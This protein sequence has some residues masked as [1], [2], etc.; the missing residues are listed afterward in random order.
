MK[1]RAVFALAALVLGLAAASALAAKD[2]LIVADQY[3]ATTMDPIGHNDVPS[4]RCCFELYDTLIFR[5]KDGNLVPGLAESW[6]FLSPTE[7]KFVLRKGVKFHNGEELKASDV[8]YTIMRATTDKGAKIRTYSQ[9][10]ADVK[11]LDDYTVVVVL[12]KPDYSF[13]GS[14]THSWGSILNEK[15]T[16]AAGDSYGTPG[17]PAVGTGP[18]T[19]VKWEKSNKYILERNDDFWGKKPAYKYLEVRAIPEPTNRTIELETKGVDIAYPII[20]NDINRI[21]DNEQLTRKERID[22]AQIMQ[23]QLEEVGIKAEIKVLEWGAYL[24]GLQEQKHDMFE[25]GW[26]SSV[27]DPNFAIS[28][29]LETKAGSNYTFSSDPKLD[30]LLAKKLLA[31]AGFP[32]GFKCEIW[33]NERKERIDMAQIMQ[34]QLEEVGIKA[35]IKVLEWGAYLNG[36]QEQKH[37]MFELGWVSSVP[38]PN[39]AI[40]GL[41]ETKAGSNYTFSSDPKL[42]ELLAKGRETPDGPERAEIYKQAQLEINE[43]CPMVF[44]HN[45]ESV[46]GSQKN[47]KGF[48]PAGNE[49]HSFRD[50]YFED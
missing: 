20:G 17:S 38:D 40:S 22:M 49:T 7:Y 45:D 21:R 24:N 23:A 8:R 28:G 31:E 25:L 3:D 16:E 27:P 48:A 2:R 42:D 30:E 11:V 26:V 10:V 19:F 41:L 18:F 9:N 34:A 4:S 6:E 37:D 14:L 1:K 15:A 39:F 33:T 32:N 36:L 35:E 12:K 5:D 44:L 50:V 29:L 43:Y 13:F 46:A 47:V